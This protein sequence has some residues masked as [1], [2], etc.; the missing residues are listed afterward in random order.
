VEQ[1]YVF[2]GGRI[3]VS[4]LLGLYAY[5]AKGFP[6]SD[7]AL[8]RKEPFSYIRVVVENADGEWG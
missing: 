2:S 4:Y 3:G 7:V 6:L 1:N 5:D 8:S